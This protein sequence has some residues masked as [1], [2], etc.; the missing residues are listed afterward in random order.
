MDFQG[1]NGDSL[2]P[3]PEQSVPRVAHCWLSQI[4]LDPYRE[5]YAAAVCRVM[6]SVAH[7]A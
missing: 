2:I 4:R 6:C 3:D 1:F 7:K 5:A